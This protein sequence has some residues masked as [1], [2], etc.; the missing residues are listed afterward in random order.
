MRLLVVAAVAN[1]K[2]ATSDGLARVNKNVNSFIHA[3]A[4]VGVACWNVRRFN[5][6]FWQF[7]IRRA[8][9]VD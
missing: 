2:P 4:S 7:H 8:S 5:D 1:E 6:D 3:T 9:S